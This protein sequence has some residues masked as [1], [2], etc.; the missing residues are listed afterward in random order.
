MNAACSLL[1]NTLFTCSSQD[2][3]WELNESSLGW[4]PIAGMS[5]HLSRMDNCLGIYLALTGNR[6]KGIELL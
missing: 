4:I 1:A 6:L 5:Y 2:S 3:L